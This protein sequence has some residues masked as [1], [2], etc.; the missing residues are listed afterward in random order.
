MPD[1][2]AAGFLVAYGTSHVALSWLARLRPGET[3]LVLGASGGVGLTAVEVGALLGARVIAVAR[4][5]GAAG[6]RA[7]GRSGASDRRRGGPARRGEGAGRGGR[8]L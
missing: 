7:A 2:E 4:E 1:A 5:R 3:L 8:G 6:D